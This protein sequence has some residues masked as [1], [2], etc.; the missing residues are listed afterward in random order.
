[1]ALSGGLL[2]IGVAEKAFFEGIA[3]EIRRILRIEPSINS[4]NRT[5]TD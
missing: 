3:R 5:R 2:S 4:S 1:M